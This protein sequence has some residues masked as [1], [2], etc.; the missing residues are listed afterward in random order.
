MQRVYGKTEALLGVQDGALAGH[1]ANTL[2]NRLAMLSS[3]YAS[4]P[5]LIAVSGRCSFPQLTLW[6]WPR[7]PSQ[8]T[9]LNLRTSSPEAEKYLRYET[10][11]QLEPPEEAPTKQYIDVDTIATIRLTLAELHTQCM[12]TS[13]FS[14]L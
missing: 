2:A 6:L 14:I 5:A 8:P 4:T 10:F 9:R 1:S 13:A 7:Q 3:K 12:S 11:K